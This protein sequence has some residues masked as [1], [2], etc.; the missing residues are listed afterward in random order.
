LNRQVHF[1]TLLLAVI[2]VRIL[3]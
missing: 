1:I 2:G 3:I